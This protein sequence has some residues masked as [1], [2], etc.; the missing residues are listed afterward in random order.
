[1]HDGCTCSTGESK[2]TGNKSVS[3]GNTYY[4]YECC[5]S[6]ATVR[7][8]CGQY[9]GCT[10]AKLC[11]SSAHSLTYAGAERS[12]TVVTPPGL[13]SGGGAEALIIGIHGWT[14]SAQWACQVMLQPYI[15]NIN[16]IGLCVQGSLN[17]FYTSGWDTG[18]TGFEALWSTNDVG[19]IKA[20]RE[21]VLG[22][23]AVPDDLTYAIGF[24]LGGAMTYR[25][26]CEA[27]DVISGFG[28][29]G[30]SGP[31]STTPLD[32]SKFPWAAG[33]AQTTPRPLWKGI[34]TNDYFFT[35]ETARNGWE[36]FVVDVLGCSGEVTDRIVADGVT[37]SRFESCAVATEFC[38]YEGMPH[39]FPSAST[40]PQGATDN[41]RGASWQATPA[42]WDVW[43]EAYSPAA[44][45][46]SDSWFCTFMKAQLKCV[47]DGGANTYCTTHEYCLDLCGITPVTAYGPGAW[48][49]DYAGGNQTAP[50]ASPF[51]TCFDDNDKCTDASMLKYSR[52]YN[53]CYL[54]KSRDDCLTG[55]LCE[56][57]KDENEPYECRLD[58]YKLHMTEC[59]IG[60]AVLSAAPRHPGAS[61]VSIAGLVVATVAILA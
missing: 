35:D 16:A 37:C 33:C 11:T 41:G 30:Q 14:Q 45:V 42:A 29:V 2:L 28:V 51:Y 18:N 38:V 12:F 55:A 61:A 4:E 32:S 8:Q 57:V 22:E 46:H 59:P 34:G 60:H 15:A 21:W 36:T 40:T 26:M 23:Y 10:D 53:A 7:D 25:L 5:T 39:I 9:T 17:S 1:M 52:E 13:A 49:Q 27:S 54:L 56:W 50:L 47:P 6:G 43:R 19:F 44:D 24:S 58:N 20:A 48:E 31:W 3:N